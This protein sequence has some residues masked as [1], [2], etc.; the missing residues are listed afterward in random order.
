[1][2]LMWGFSYLINSKIKFL[3]PKDGIEQQY[4]K[5]NHIEDFSVDTIS[6]ISK[7]IL[8]KMK[9]LGIDD[10][11][12]DDRTEIEESISDIVKDAYNQEENDEEVDSL[13]E[14]EDYELG[15][16]LKNL[17]SS[18][19]EK[20]IQETTFIDEEKIEEV[21]TNKKENNMENLK[22]IEEITS[23]DDLSEE[24]I[25]AAFNGTEVASKII[26]N[27]GKEVSIKLDKPEDIKEF[28]AKLLESKAIEITVKVKE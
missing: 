5:D 10:D 1:M 11:E 14:N 27:K 20:N 12:F 7:H 17:L 13:L 15:D 22:N 2:C 28:L 6:D 26:D 18:N 4:L 3:K 16:D 23:L 8:K 19:T 21:E 9:L 24:D 25:M